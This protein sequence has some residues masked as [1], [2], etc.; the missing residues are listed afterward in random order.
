MIFPWRH[1]QQSPPEKALMS[2]P[3]PM[4]TDLVRS[5]PLDPQAVHRS[6]EL[7]K[8]LLTELD[9][10]GGPGLAAG[11]SELVRVTNSDVSLGARQPET[12]VDAVLL[13]VNLLEVLEPQREGIPVHG[14]AGQGEMLDRQVW[15]DG[16]PGAADNDLCL[17]DAV[18]VEVLAVPDLG[19]DLSV[20][21][22]TT[23]E[24]G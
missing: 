24:S 8:C 3:P 14:E 23:G 11:H 13:E 19:A 6:G 20:A 5:H 2:V 10:P 9:S 18:L 16:E 7:G 4:D 17:L 21:L 1:A 22:A 12:A 15:G